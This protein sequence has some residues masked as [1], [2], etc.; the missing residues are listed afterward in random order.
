MGLIEVESE[1]DQ[2][3]A[4]I[5]KL[6]RKEADLIVFDDKRKIYRKRI[7]VDSLVNGKKA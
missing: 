3:A 7:N 2:G 4:F 1:P 6:P 5:I